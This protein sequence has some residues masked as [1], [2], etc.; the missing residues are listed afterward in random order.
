VCAAAATVTIYVY[1]NLPNPAVVR[2]P[3]TVLYITADG[4]GGKKVYRFVGKFFRERRGSFYIIIITTGARRFTN[5]AR[6]DDEYKRDQKRIYGRLK[7]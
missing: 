4:G 3:L 7:G 1:A 5:Y 6:A 2:V